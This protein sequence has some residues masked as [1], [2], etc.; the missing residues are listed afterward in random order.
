[1]RREGKIL[2]SFDRGTAATREDILFF[3]P[4]DAVY[5]SII[6]NAVGCNR[7]RCTGIETTGTYNYDGLVYIYNIAPELDELLENEM[8]MQTLAQYKMYLPLRQIFVAIPL[9]IKSKEIPEKEVVKTLLTLRP[10][11][12]MGMSVAEVPVDCLFLRW[13]V[14]SAE[15]LKH[16]GAVVGKS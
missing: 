15:L 4:G 16:M 13:S 14:L 7:G 1:M 11:N 3:A 12:G 8:P 2:G 10:N 5:D 6:S 9:N